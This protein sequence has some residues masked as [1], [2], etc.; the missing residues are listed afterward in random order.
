M[1]EK[2]FLIPQGKS[3]AALQREMNSGRFPPYICYK[4]LY[5]I[6]EERQV[7]PIFLKVE[8]H[9]ADVALIFTRRIKVP[10][11]EFPGLFV[12]GLHCP[13]LCIHA[14]AIYILL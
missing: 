12:C 9:G 13:H 8:L 2:D 14:S 10:E 3:K 4:I 6:P 7:M 11:S 1:R 5:S